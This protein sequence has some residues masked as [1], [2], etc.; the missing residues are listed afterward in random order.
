MQ[1]GNMTLRSF[2][3][4]DEEQT[5]RV[6]NDI[7][8]QHFIPGAYC[9]DLDDARKLVRKYSEEF[10]GRYGYA[11]AVSVNDKMVGAVILADDG[12][13]ID[14]AYMIAG[15][16]RGNGYASK[17]LRMAFKWAKRNTNFKEA[18]LKIEEGN[19]ASE[20]VACSIGA[21]YSHNE[22]GDDVYIVKL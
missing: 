1:E 2:K 14:C 4:G 19:H 16:E 13:K 18:I 7:K 12:G 8:I 21:R 6:M 20:R 15:N 11:L 22:Y 17:A 3:D 5:L 10:N 9:S